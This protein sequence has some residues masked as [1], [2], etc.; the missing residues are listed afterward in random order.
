[1]PPGRSPVPFGGGPRH[2]SRTDRRRQGRI[3]LERVLIAGL[4][5]VTLAT[6]RFPIEE[7]GLSASQYWIAGVAGA[8]LFFASLLAHEMG[9]ALVARREGLS[10]TGISLWLFGGLTRFESNPETAGAEL[11]V[12][13][14]RPAHHRWR[15]RACSSY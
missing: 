6:N 9:H 14:D 8:L 7:P 3:Q 1:M 5:T 15:V 13:A 12:A 4:Y 2:P 10:V 11:R